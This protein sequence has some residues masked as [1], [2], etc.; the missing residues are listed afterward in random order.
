MFNTI[1]KMW[2]LSLRKQATSSAPPTFLQDLH[3]SSSSVWPKNNADLWAKCNI[4]NLLAQSTFSLQILYTASSFGSLFLAASKTDKISIV[5]NIFGCTSSR[6]YD[7][8][9]MLVYV[10]LSISDELKVLS[11]FLNPDGYLE[12]DFSSG[13]MIRYISWLNIY[14]YLYFLS[15]PRKLWS[16]LCYYWMGRSVFLSMQRTK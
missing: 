13:H 2:D 15:I 7:H 1:F 16:A 8:E 11:L 4:P 14:Q 9:V 3:D 10:I 6:P 12:P 5:T